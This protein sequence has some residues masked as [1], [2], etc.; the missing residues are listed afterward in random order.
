MNTSPRVLV[1]QQVR[2][3]RR[4]LMLQTLLH[5]LLVAWA[6]ALVATA[7]WFLIRP[8]AFPDAAAWL[9]W[10]IPAI[11]LGFGTLTA[12]V[13]TW[14]TAPPLMA[15]SL[16]LDERCDLKERIT[17]FLMLPDSMI[18]SSAG[19]ALLEDV[20]HQLATLNTAG[21]FPIRVRW[22]T[23]L[24]PVLACVLVLGASLLGP[25]LGS[26]SFA[27][28]ETKVN[29]D[30]DAKEIQ[31]QLDNLRKASFTPK[32]PE[33]KSEEFK[34]LEAAWDKLVNKPLDPNNED[35]IRERVNEMKNLEEAF[36]QRAEALKNQ[37]GKTKELMNLLEQLALDDK[38]LTAGPAKDL[39]DA[40]S[41][42]NLEKAREI[43]EKLAKDLK[44]GKLDPQKQ[45]EMA[46]QFEQLQKNLERLLQRDDLKKQL[47][48]KFKKGE[49]T[50]EQLDRELKNLKNLAQEMPDLKELADL[51]GECKE[52]MKDGDGEKA[53]DALGKGKD[54]L[55]TIELSEDELQEL[56]DRLEDLEDAENAIRAQLQG[57]GM[58]GGPRPGA[59]R[60]IDPDDPNSKIVNERQKARVDPRG[61]H[62]VTGFAKGGTFQKVPAKEIGGAFRQAAQDAPEAL[63]RQRIPQDAADIARGYFSKLG[64][65]E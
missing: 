29:N 54:R 22:Q 5:T 30:I 33:L 46:K 12:L 62:R 24:A 53:A 65:Q 32:D 56:M 42:G 48:E 19:Q 36:K 16:A 45:K 31:Q 61:T 39:E 43:L 44:D 25:T 17:T 4:R 6:A 8:L 11:F 64:R 38:K 18:T 60:P 23:A 58:G 35:K 57:N 27:R 1:E 21:K 3:V 7:V 14:M 28:N 34:E 47:Q 40:L 49:I 9:R 55:K 15:A 50:K 10:A 13:W 37:L 41:K 52:C 59:E 26:I 2:K 51:I 63:D 20:Q